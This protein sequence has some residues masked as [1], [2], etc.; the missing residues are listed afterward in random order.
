M[1]MR[2]NLDDLYTSFESD[3]FLRDFELAKQEVKDRNSWAK[4]NLKS[5]ENAMQKLEMFINRGNEFKLFQKIGSYANLAG[6][7]DDENEAA[8]KY[9]D[10]FRTELADLAVSE[11]MF[12]SFVGSL[13]NLQEL[14]DASPI[15][16]EHEF[17]LT[18]IMKNNKYMLSEKEEIIL[19]KYRTTG[20]MAWSN[21]RNQITSTLKIDVMV[22]GEEK[23]LPLTAVRNLA[24]SANAQTRKAAYFAEQQGYEEVEKPT[25]AALNSIKG[26][27]LTNVK[28]RGYKD[29]LDMTL[30]NYKMQKETLDAMLSSME[31]FLPSFRRFYKKKAQI[32][33]HSGSLPFYD[34]FAPVGKVDL[35]FSYAE[36]KD[37][38]IENFNI[39]SKEMGDFA[40]HAFDN[41]WLD[42]EVRDGKR[43]GAFCHNLHSIGQSRIMSNYDGSFSNLT[44]L[45]H[46]LGHA[47][48]GYCLKNVP[49]LKSS[50]SMPIAETAST[51][52]ET[53]ITDAAI[54][55]ADKEQAFAILQEQISDSLQVIVDIYSRFVFESNL[56]AKRES[57][58][59]SV[60]EINELMLSAQIKA[61]GDGLDK[62]YLHKYMW[63]NKPH[64][65]A[66]HNNF[67]NFP[68]AYGLLF[69]LGLYAQYL[70]EGKGFVPK[71][72]ELLAATGSNT[73]EK[74]G[75]LAGIDVRKSD[76]WNL[77]L[78][79]V[80]EKVDK[81]C[82]Y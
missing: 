29:A 51:F 50:Y 1:D 81:F 68:Y 16:K 40:R 6:S 2:W 25:A 45:A 48:H 3:E 38:I 30:V 14:I 5:S 11:V 39:Y 15:L 56:F 36:A 64:Y 17:M 47:Y 7:V 44:T 20:S 12:N 42:V 55:N 69:S 71:Y 54:K 9:L 58:P 66:A 43:G 33:G 24:Y 80:E 28:L 49:F 63:I 27:A 57:G 46:E 23:S 52:C 21:M 37:F 75:D 19:A 22:E 59:L 78:K 73:L 77:S 4:E 13:S 26:E 62:E 70:K 53:L 82:S 65:Y 41:N 72:N 79:L 67:Y 18:E 32:L 10:I 60:S 34:I 35:T 61:Y 8:K 74:I 76:F 31:S